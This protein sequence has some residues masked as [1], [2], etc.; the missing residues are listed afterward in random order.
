MSGRLGP[1]VGDAVLNAFAALPKT[2]KPQPN[3]HTVLAGF[4]LARLEPG[5]ADP[6]APSPL[7][8]VSLG[9]GTKCLGASKRTAQGGVLHDSHAEAVARRA[10]LAWAYGEA[11]LALAAQAGRGD[12]GCDGSSGPAKGASCPQPEA[13]AKATTAGSTKAPASVFEVVEA[14]PTAGGDETRSTEGAGAGLASPPRLRLRLRPGL[15]LL[16]YVSQPPCG[17]CSILHTAGEDRGQGQ[18]QQGEALQAA[19]HGSTRACCASGGPG[20]QACASAPCEPGGAPHVAG[21]SD[22]AASAGGVAAASVAPAAGGSVKFRTGAKA[23]RLMAADGQAGAGASTGSPDALSGP[24]AAAGAGGAGVLVPVL[25]QAGDVDVAAQE[26][27]EALGAVRR[28]PG[29]GDATPSLSCSD[30]LSRWCCLGLQGSLLSG[31]LEAPLTLHSLAVGA[32]P[33]LEEAAG[34]EAA[35]AAVEAAARRCLEERLQ[36]DPAAAAL[37]ARHLPFGLRPPAVVALPQPHERFALRPGGPRKVPSGVSINWS[38]PP[39]AAMARLTPAP[40]APCATAASTDGAR[41]PPPVRAPAPL[42]PNGA[43]EVTLS[44]EG[45]RAGAAK[46]SAVWGAVAEK[47]RSRLCRVALGRRMAALLDS[48]ASSGGAGGP[49]PEPRPGPGTTAGAA[50]ATDLSYAQL[51]RALAP[52]YAAAWEELRQPPGLFSRWLPKP[53]GEQGFHVGGGGPEAGPAAG[54]GPATKQRQEEVR[55]QGGEGGDASAGANGAVADGLCADEGAPA[56][57]Q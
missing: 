28:K 57:V 48:L 47:T 41:P 55:A 56:A 35:L 53:A 46:R 13:A 51:K 26:G 1:A 36:A 37:A 24:A 2:G 34:R 12:S 21:H 11:E 44:A 39:G 4:A 18:G 6:S 8:V 25:P 30:K 5:A 49:A 17:D 45:R 3:E 31:I 50:A 27:G 54:P 52:R 38:A 40:P 32:P 33:G 22:A 42:A 15:V 29:R 14:G 43:H 20:P 10:L 19:P 23:I 9:T 7:L 16:M